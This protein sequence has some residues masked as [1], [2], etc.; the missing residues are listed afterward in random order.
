[1]GGFGGGGFGQPVSG[2]GLVVNEQM[3]QQDLA[4][5][6]RVLR[7]LGTGTDTTLL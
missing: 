1:M 4:E 7:P 5:V 2:G 6:L 3:V